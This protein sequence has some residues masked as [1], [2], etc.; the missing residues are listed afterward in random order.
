MIVS[1]ERAQW[2]AAYALGLAVADNL[3]D[4]ATDLIEKA[5]ADIEL[6]ELA[7]GHLQRIEVADPASRRRATELLT[8]AASLI[9]R[10]LPPSW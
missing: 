5:D 4:A 7:R 1:D 9:R 8:E 6:L 2:L 3:E 10:T